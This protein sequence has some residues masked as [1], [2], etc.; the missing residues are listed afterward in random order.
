MRLVIIESPYSGSTEVDIE[1]NRIYLQRCIRDSIIRG[2]S[3]YASHQMLTQALDD[4]N[5]EE[6]QIGIKAG[7]S[8]WEAVSAIVF[9]TDL[10][11]SSGMKQAYERACELNMKTEERKLPS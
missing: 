10:G 9:Y 4:N 11:W 1:R 7:Y 5:K 6:R 2:E 8:W 3:P